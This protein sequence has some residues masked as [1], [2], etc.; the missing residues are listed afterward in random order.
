[1][2]LHFASAWEAV[3]DACPEATAI[4]QGDRRCSYAAFDDRAARFAG[5][6]DAAGLGVDTKVSLYLYNSP[7]YLIA[8]HGA[9]KARAVPVNVNYRYLDDELAYLID[10]SDSEV[11][12]FHTSL[13]DRV[14]R[15]VDRLPR[16][17]LLVEV[18]DGGTHVDGA[19]AFDE[20]VDAHERMP[21][22]DRPG[23]DLYML[24]TGGTT[25][26]PKGVMYRQRDFVQGLYDAFAM[27]G[28]P[29]ATPSSTEE[30]PAFVDAMAQRPR[31]VSV[32][33]PPLMHGTGMWVGGMPPLLSGGT[34]VLLESRS[35]DAHELW[36]TV[37][38]ERVTRITI[39][40][41]A[42]AR[43]MLRALE[44]LEDQSRH[45]DLTSVDTIVSSG[46]MWS[47]E[48]KDGLTSRL[49]AFLIDAL[50][51]TEGGGY[52][53]TAAARGLHVETAK[54]QLAPTTRVLTPDDRDVEAGSGEPG[55]LA[56]ASAAYGYYKDEEKTAGTFRQIDGTSYVLTGDWAT[57]EADGTITLLGRGSNCI[58]SG[59]EKIYP[60]E[61]EEALKRHE[62]VD[63][64]LVVG[65]P[66][67]RLG[68][69]I[70]AVAG[71][72]AAD[73]PDGDELRAWLRSSLSGYKIPK[74]IVVVDQVRRAPNG[75]ADYGWAKEVATSVAEPT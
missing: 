57:V 23:D 1:V 6:M 58:N 62:A 51:S 73:H 19:V 5:A 28:L 48:I 72:T 68:Q 18:D 12:V 35:F 61:V 36:R 59:G 17:R 47:A 46:A 63:D 54:F 11:L 29:V 15:V 26:M 38:R 69:Q 41:D 49:D 42:F 30:I 45:L 65:V 4:V 71:S 16:L 67:E 13:G 20:L 75:K 39:V 56:S 74:S 2:D 33:C 66:H 55:L 43:P 10:N 27:L 24:Y 3:A 64:C 9:F 44:E 8:Q 37:E 70:V 31:F 50:G 60:E 14:A 40:G 32:P 53:V 34:A 25:G 22:T 52:A 7:E 21:R